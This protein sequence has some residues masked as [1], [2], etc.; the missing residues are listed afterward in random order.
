MQQLKDQNIQRQKISVRKSY[1]F[2]FFVLVV[3]TVECLFFSWVEDL[4]TTERLLTIWN[5]ITKLVKYWEA[6]LEAKWPSLKSYMNVKMAVADDLMPAKLKCFCFI[7]DIVKPFLTK[8]QT[9]KP[10]VPCLCL[11]IVKI[12]RRLMQLI[13]KQKTLD[14]YSTFLDHKE[15]ILD[16][17]N[18][19]VKPK[20]IN[21]GFGARSPLTIF[22]RKDKVKSSDLAEFFTNT[23][24]FILTIIK[25][26]FE[27][28]PAAS[29]VVKNTSLFDPRVLA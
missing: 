26:L 5:D 24:L 21:T 15:V 23:V 16:N 25:K 4:P 11:D 28:S 6:L 9:D 20:N 18:T 2:T 17:K 13:V 29:S 22:G 19:M 3:G 10:M 12:I 7:A 1:N 27:K 8:Y 14:K